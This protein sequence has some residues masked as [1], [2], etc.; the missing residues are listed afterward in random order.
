MKT[1]YEQFEGMSFYRD[2]QVQTVLKKHQDHPFFKSF[3]TYAFEGEDWST[4]LNT[5]NMTYDLHKKIIY[6]ALVKLLE[7]TSDGFS[8]SGLNTLQSNTPYLY[9]SNHR[10]IVMDAILIN[11]ALLEKE[12]IM[13]ASAIGDNLLTMPILEDFYKIN[14]NFIVNRTAKGREAVSSAIKLS[15]FILT[16]LK[17]QRSVWI[18]QKEGRALGGVDKT[19]ASVLKMIGIAKEKEMTIS[20]YFSNLKAI[21]VS[22]SYEWDSNDALK[23]DFVLSKLKNRPP[24]KSENDDFTHILN[25]INGHKGRIKINFGLP[26]HETCSLQ[27]LD[28]MPTNKAFKKLAEYFDREIQ[29]NYHLFPNAYAALDLINDSNEYSD[30]YKNEDKEMLLERRIQAIQLYDDKE[31]AKT[32]FLKMYAAPLVAKLHWEQHT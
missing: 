6:P 31:L 9:I 1:Q 17:D 8:Y 19:Q 13:T 11:M 4:I 12:F 5:C 2:G 25:G 14:R 16:L 22:I 30:F 3:M 32:E 18:A 10:D 7:N 20:Q 23:L 24:K 15:K 29:S 28:D 26:I 27:S 21:P